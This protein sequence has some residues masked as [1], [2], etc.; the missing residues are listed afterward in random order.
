MVPDKRPVLMWG[1][2]ATAIACMVLTPLYSFVGYAAAQDE[3]EDETEKVL[4]IGFMQPVD[5]L[6]P[7]L[8]LNDAAYVF[9]GLVYDNPHCIDT[10]MEIESNLVIGTR[11]VPASDPEIAVAGRPYGSIWEYDIT[12]NARWHDGEPFLI[13]DFVWNMNLHMTYY[14]AMWAFQPYSFFMEKV[15]K[16]DEDTA[17]IYYFNRDTEEPMACAYAYLLAVP[18]LPRHLLSTWTPFEIAFNWTGIF[19]NEAIPLV[20][21]GPFMVTS[22]LESEFRDGDHLTLV[23]NPNYHWDEDKGKNISFDKVVMYFYDDATSMRLALTSGDLDIAQF[24]PEN[25]KALKDGIADGTY[26]NLQ[27]Y[28]GRKCTQYWTEIEFC[29]NDGGPNPSRLDPAI[30][31][32]LATATDKS[33]IVNNYYRGLADEGTTL[34]PAINTKWHY[35]P[36]A[37]EKFPYDPDLA[38]EMLD[39]AGY[40]YPYDNAEFRVAT[41]DS[42]AVKEGW[43]SEGKQLVYHMYIRREYPEEALIAQYLKEKWA[44]IGVGIDY[45]VV[46]E[47]YMSTQVYSYEY[48]T[49]IWYWSADIDP[50]YMLFCQSKIAWSGWSDNKYYNESYEENY[51]ASVSAMDYDERKEYVDNCQRVHYRDAAFII[52]ATPYQT[53]VWRTDTFENWGDWDENPGM[54]MDNFWTGN[55]LFFELEY[56]GEESGG[57]DLMS[58]LMFGAVIAAVVAV[59]VAVWWL[60]KKGKKGKASPLGE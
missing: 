35:E 15:E 13:D 59:A 36:T 5:S 51:W 33:Y 46:D 26:S 14:D 4:K 19:P 10:Q 16:V 58:A 12:P 40:R 30:R 28:D 41:T 47:A 60:K 32:A 6:S 29:M 44:E 3:G 1:F 49:C 38:E 53:Y 52:M 25:Y 2:V 34:I 20:G 54:S 56:I 22:Q 9:Y 23:R 11:P 8:G 39:D 55:P 43:V 45:D 57:F 17:R 48:D 24:P 27:A 31:Q 50:N 21:T 42:L 7:M 37:D 18:M